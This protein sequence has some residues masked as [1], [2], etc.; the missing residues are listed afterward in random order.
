MSTGHVLL[1]LESLLL[2]LQI[3]LFQEKSKTRF[4]IICIVVA[5]CYLNYHL[6]GPRWEKKLILTPAKKERKKVFRICVFFLFIYVTPLL[7]NS[8]SCSLWRIR[9]T[10]RRNTCHMCSRSVYF[11]LRSEGML[12]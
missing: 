5:S 7:K 6:S 3:K 4:V 12:M 10:D 8:K 11:G 9:V 1:I 2:L